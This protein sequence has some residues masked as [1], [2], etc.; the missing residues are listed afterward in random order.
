MATLYLNIANRSGYVVSMREIDPYRCVVNIQ[1]GL[2]SDASGKRKW[3]SV[4][5]TQFRQ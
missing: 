3:W 4:S 5:V 2:V 1:P